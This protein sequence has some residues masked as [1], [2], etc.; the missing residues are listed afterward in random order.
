MCCSSVTDVEVTE[1]SESFIKVTARALNA[2]FGRLQ[3]AAHTSEC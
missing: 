2:A 3:V 1:S